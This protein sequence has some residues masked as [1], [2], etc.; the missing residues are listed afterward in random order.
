M[1]DT[2]ALEEQLA[3]PLLDRRLA[4]LGELARSAPKA[5]RGTNLHVHS[6]HSFGVFRSP[7]EAAWNA[8]KA[9]VEAFG[10]NDFFTVAG[11]DEGQRAARI[12][13]LPTVTCLECIALDATTAA[14]GTLINDPA[15]PGKVYLCGK[16]VTNPGD[17]GANRR[18]AELRG[19]QE[20]RNRALIAK[21]DERFRALIDRAGPL[22]DDVAV[23]TPA[24][25]TTERHVA[26]A[27]VRRLQVLADEHVGT[28]DQLFATV[29]GVAPKPLDADRQNQV[30]A[31]LLKAGKS[32]YAPEDPAAFPDVAG[33]RTIFLGLGAIPVYPVL[34]NPITGGESDIPALF[35]RIASWGFHAV[36]L[37]PARN[38]DD[39][40][41][42][43]LGECQRRGWPVCDGTE[44]NTP[45]MEPMLTK[46]GMDERFRPQF[47]EGA[48]VL[49]G[50]QALRARGEP[51]YIDANGAPAADGYRRCLAE[52]ERAVLAV[53]KA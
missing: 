32:C 42:A 50:H 17:A 25:N 20:R 1:T 12:L 19:H 44:H 28:F 31:E 21:V 43:V 53:A 38:T 23:Q 22:W 11:H 26:R 8:A 45:A 36:E 14:A 27:V 48:L 6:N 30:R 29:V 13:A 35:A 39:R 10:L 15:N 4:A 7:S 5:R 9:G 16:A 37:I 52:G 24:G 3:D 51:G 41:A 49:L 40:V 18:L 2:A 46:W 34:G 47:R 33:L